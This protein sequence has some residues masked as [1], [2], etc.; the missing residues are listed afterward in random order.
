MVHGGAEVAAS[1]Y[2][3][4]MVSLYAMYGFEHVIIGQV[5]EGSEVTTYLWFKSIILYLFQVC[6]CVRTA[7]KANSYL[8]R[9]TKAMK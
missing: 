7:T 5:L 9:E 2:P 6:S 3:L 4:S 8:P 1:R